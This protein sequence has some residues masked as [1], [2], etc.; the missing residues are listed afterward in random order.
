MGIENINHVVV[1]V[2]ENR[3]FDHALGYLTAAGRSD[4]DGI[5]P[6]FT[7]PNNATSPATEVAPRLLTVPRFAPSPNHE[8]AHVRMQIDPPRGGGS[9]RGFVD[10]YSTVP[11]VLE[12]G[13]VMGYYDASTLPVYDFLAREY[14]VCDRWFCAV[15]G[16]TLVNRAFLMAGHSDDV[17][18]NLTMAEHFLTRRLETVFDRLDANEVGERGRPA[19]RSY[20]HDVPFLRMFRQF[21]LSLGPI[22]GIDR[23]YK[24]AA[25][26]T[27]PV[28]S[29]IDP[30]FEIQGNLYLPDA[31]NDD[32]P[33]ANVQKGQRLVA[34]VYNAL[35]ASP[36]WN[37]TLLIIT[38]DE[39]GG[40]FDHVV[41]PIRPERAPFRNPR[42]NQ[43]GI[44]VPAFLVSPWV[45]R[46]QAIHDELEHTSII[47]TVLDR[48]CPGDPVDSMGERV[49]TAPSLDKYLSNPMRA[50]RPAAPPLDDLVDVPICVGGVSEDPVPLGVV[51]LSELA[52]SL[53][54]LRSRLLALGVPWHLT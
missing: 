54:S 38:Y 22:R 28:L 39:H 52:T 6:G 45:A 40:F 7:N 43:F 41:P 13:M 49:A 16:P 25:N 17:V 47:K 35:V 29:W 33:P 44:R 26:G 32:H 14:C 31:G 12:P 9:M 3:S 15:P 11:G 53:G 51:P 8:Y 2:L 34:R 1:L 36:Q 5:Q 23:F 4:I 42:F 21:A 37:E 24:D 18:D 50:D 46:G 48:F 27:L 10:D 30:N 20:F 19:W